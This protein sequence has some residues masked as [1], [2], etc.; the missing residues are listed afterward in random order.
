MNTTK[1]HTKRILS[2]VSRNFSHTYNLTLPETRCLKDM[3]IGILKSKTVFVN[4]IAASLRESI[5]LRK[6]AKRLSTQYL[7]DDYAERV[8][9]NHLERS[10]ERRV[11]KEDRTQRSKEE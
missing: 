5:P 6:T 9:A 8:R 3:T 7:K 11:G 1:I 4:Q 2:E 10:E